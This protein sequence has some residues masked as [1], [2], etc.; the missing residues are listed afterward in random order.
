MSSSSRSSSSSRRRSYGIRNSRGTSVR[1]R[2]IVSMQKVHDLPQP[3]E[4]CSTGTCGSCRN[5]RSAAG[6][7]R[8]RTDAATTKAGATPAAV[9]ATA[10]HGARLGGDG[11]AERC[12]AR[13]HRAGHSLRGAPQRRAVES[14]ISIWVRTPLARAPIAVN[15]VNGTSPPPRHA[16]ALVK[17]AASAPELGA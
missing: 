4:G 5:R 3:S 11:L 2:D 16:G 8:R 14:R 13:H 12:E 17:R 6:A 15:H 7:L 10:R 1:A 9:A